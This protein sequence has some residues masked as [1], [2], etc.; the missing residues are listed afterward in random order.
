M[1]S[2]GCGLVTRDSV[3]VCVQPVRVGADDSDLTVDSQTVEVVA[4]QV[5]RRWRDAS[6]RVARIARRD[7]GSKFGRFGR[8]GEEILD[9][10][11]EEEHPQ[12]QEDR[13]AR[14]DE[15]VLGSALASARNRGLRTCPV[16]EHDLWSPRVR[17][18]R[19]GCLPDGA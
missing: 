1:T 3:A 15:R 6:S 16:G 12:D 9:L 18:W 13:D 2:L 7:R 4:V 14:D 17:S 10:P 5:R 19:H 11:G 8:S